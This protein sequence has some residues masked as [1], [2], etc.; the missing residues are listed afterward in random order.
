[1]TR[2]VIVLAIVIAVAAGFFMAGWA[3]KLMRLNHRPLFSYEQMQE[4]FLR[5]DRQ[6]PHDALLL[7]GDSHVAGLCE[8]CLSVPAIN[9]GI[10]GDTVAGLTRRVHAYQSVREPSNIAI[11][12]IGSND[13]MW[14][15][16]TELAQDYAVLLQHLSGLKHVFAYATFP[17]AK[18][19]SKP[20]YNTRVANA[21]TQLRAACA[22]MKNCTFVV[23]ENLYDREGYLRDGLHMPDG[24]HLTEHGYLL[25]IE[26]IESML[27]NSQ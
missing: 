15:H 2:N 23:L 3:A 6:Q 20:S 13:V 25:W 21:A 10:G 7:L 14:E 19:S 22:A 9:L 12:E 27:K 8:G 1:M 16:K 4:N 26:H 5:K 18:T 24:I 11:I 17:I